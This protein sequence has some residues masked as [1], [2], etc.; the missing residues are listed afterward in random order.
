MRKSIHFLF[1]CLMVLPCSFLSAQSNLDSLRIKLGL[2]VPPENIHL[3]LDKDIYLPSETI[4]FKAYILSKPG[5]I[6]H[7]ANLFTELRDGEGKLVTEFT[8]PIIDGVSSGQFTLPDSMISQQLVIRAFT[9]VSA[10]NE[11]VF[12]KRIRVIGEKIQAEIRTEAFPTLQLFA[13]G[14]TFI[15]NVPNVVSFK[16]TNGYGL[17]YAIKGLIRDNEDRLIDSIQT[18]HDGMGSFLFY[19]RARETY[20]VEWKDDSGQLHKTPFP[21]STD[22]GVSLQVKL[23][24]KELTYFIQNPVP[25]GT[26]SE[27][28]VVATAG[29]QLVFAARIHS[30]G[31]SATSGHIAVDSLAT[32]ILQLTVFN[33]IME[34]LAERIVFINNH[35]YSFDTDIKVIERSVA[36]RG[37]NVVEISVKDSLRQNL[38]VAIADAG[39]VQ[40]HGGNIFTNLLLTGDIKGYVHDPA[41]Y[42]RD[43]SEKM[44]GYLDLVMQTNGWR[45]YNWNKLLNDPTILKE[46]VKDEYISFSGRVTNKEFKPV[47]DALVSLMIRTRD[48]SGQAFILPTDENGVFNQTGLVFSDSASIYYS[49]GGLKKTDDLS[50]SIIPA[51]SL[52]FPKVFFDTVIYAGQLPGGYKRGDHFAGSRTLILYRSVTAL[53]KRPKYWNL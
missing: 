25:Q 8:A 5:A 45:R 41:Q 10:L 46:P 16:A 49:L 23:N 35:E 7:S 11:N 22:T 2:Q 15:N 19:P 48:S 53:R 26:L 50:I 34:P 33:K 32:G 30:T 36:K 43:S 51:N 40:D 27:L 39:L 28:Y 21:I 9:R 6:F 29:Q 31:Q 17:P 12:I 38:S 44:K 52:S 4:W 3:H 20:F 42:F 1:S 18:L 14:G 13:E 24:Q 47:N 37:R